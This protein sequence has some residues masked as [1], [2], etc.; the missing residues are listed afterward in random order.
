MKYR[1]L[2]SLLFVL[3]FTG[4]F[5]A[6][7]EVLPAPAPNKVVV[8]HETRQC[9]LIFGG[10]ECMDCFPPEGWEV[11]GYYP[12]VLCPEGYEEVSDLEIDCRHFQNDHCC[13]E[14][15]SGASGDCEN[16]VINSHQELCAFIENAAEAELPSGW[17]ARPGNTPLQEWLCPYGLEGWVSEIPAESP[18]PT[19]MEKIKTIPLLVYLVLGLCCCLLF[20]LLVLI[21]FFIF[22]K[23]KKQEKAI[24]E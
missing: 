19:L 10:D 6:N 11:L 24:K 15:H 14:G 18:A 7:A 21:F 9:A 22:R 3:G 12:D 17:K 8:N 5:S 13:T 16:M 4:S 23:K 1:L 2:I 20:V